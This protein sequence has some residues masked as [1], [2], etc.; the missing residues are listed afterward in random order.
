MELR[1]FKWDAQV[2]DTSVLS[3]LPLLMGSASWRELEELSER[4]FAETLAAEREILARRSLQR[5]MGVP[6]PLERL[7]ARG[8][9][10][11]AAARVMRFDFHWTRDGW[12]VSEVNADVPGGYCEASHFSALMAEQ[13]PGTRAA[14]DPTRALVDA[15]VQSVGGRGLVAL[16]NAAG[17]M[18]DHQVMA[19]LAS[20][21]RERGLDSQVASLP[22]LSWSEGRASL[23]VGAHAPR[24]LAAIV[25]FYQVEWLARLPRSSDF[26]C[27]FVGGR[28]PLVN[29]GL[30]GLCESKRFPLVWD[31][32]SAPLPTWRRL[33]PETR[34][35]GEAPYATDDGW[36]I[37]SSYCNTGDTVS[38][39]AA[40]TSAQWARRVFFARLNPSA[41]VAQRRFVTEPVFDEQGALFPCIGVYVIDGRAA[42][43][44]A[45]M[46]R[47]P[48]ID[49]AAFDA[50]LLV[51]DEA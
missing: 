44:Y 50:A 36:L 48:V 15:V 37:K 27:L 45:R 31:E 14:G 25:R 20:A 9:P 42:G 32:L 47:G 49:F 30:A 24:A 46:S 29:P 51:Y 13:V 22:Q 10:S 4:L 23:A 8:V 33:L 26:G 11:P 40:M 19:H 35:L 3:A 21:L 39:R 18:E 12:R 38:M 28:T 6:R 17:H 5:R 43:A 2:G 34:A 7:F 16:T 41:W 1:H